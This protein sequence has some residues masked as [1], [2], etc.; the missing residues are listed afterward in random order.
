MWLL[1]FIPDSLIVY[2]INMTV[3]AGIAITVAGTFMGFIPVVNK[4]KTV[5]H[6]IGIVLLV[7]GVYCKGVFSTDAAMREQ[8]RELQAKIDVAEKKAQE[9][10]TQVQ[11]KIVTKIVKIQ[12]KS[13][14]AK[15]TLRRKKDTIN[16]ECNL[17]DDAISAYNFSI[18][19]TPTTPGETK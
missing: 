6:L 18:T 10:N 8:V 7:L 5:L 15:E 3:L 17:S 1:H 9:A 13:N 2:V 11:T 4:Y 16:A 19:K 14:T 12:D